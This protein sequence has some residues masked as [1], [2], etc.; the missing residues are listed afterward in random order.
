[1]SRNSQLPAT[2]QQLDLIVA[3]LVAKFP[4]GM[5][6]L[7]GGVARSV[8]DLGKIAAE[9]RDLF[10][11]VHVADSAAKTARKARRERSPDLRKFLRELRPVLETAFGTDSEELRSFGYKPRKEPTPLTGEE[12]VARRDKSNATREQLHTLGPRQKAELKKAAAAPPAA[13]P[14]STGHKD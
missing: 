14:D 5:T 6:L 10:K 13:S 1:M 7:F 8:D 3:N 12:M 11:A 9:H 4:A 2:E